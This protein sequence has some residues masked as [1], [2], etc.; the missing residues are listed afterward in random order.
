VGNYRQAVY[1]TYDTDVNNYEIKCFNTNNIA[2]HIINITERKKNRIFRKSIWQDQN[3][4]DA[5]FKGLGEMA[6]LR[7]VL[8]GST[9][10][11]A[12]KPSV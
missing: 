2:P 6:Y 7:N 5:I 8:L 11:V 10:L 3:K 12:T 9:F 1:S 4:L